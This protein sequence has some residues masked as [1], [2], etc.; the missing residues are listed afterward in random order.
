MLP[1]DSPPLGKVTVLPGVVRVSADA[2]CMYDVIKDI[3]VNNIRL[4]ERCILKLFILY[5]PVC[6]EFK[7]YYWQNVES[8]RNIM[9]IVADQSIN[10]TDSNHFTKLQAHHG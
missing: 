7:D 2:K 4:V 9:D 10:Y 5:S 3:I 6:D 8:K 1:L